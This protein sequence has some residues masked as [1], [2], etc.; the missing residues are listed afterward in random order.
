MTRH[1][2]EQ[3]YVEPVC[4]RHNKGGNIVFADGHVELL[5]NAKISHGPGAVAPYYNYPN[6][7]TWHPGD[8]YP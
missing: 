5:N 8:S 4:G 3:S 1:G 6:L 7:V 2:A